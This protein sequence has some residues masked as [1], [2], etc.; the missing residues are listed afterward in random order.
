VVSVESYE[1]EVVT[2]LVTV[3]TQAQSLEP[4]DQYLWGEVGE[5]GRT[6]REVLGVISRGPF[7]SALVEVRKPDGNVVRSFL[8]GAYDVVREVS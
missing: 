7:G 5:T 2:M 4:G 6:F 3:Y 8:N 1:M